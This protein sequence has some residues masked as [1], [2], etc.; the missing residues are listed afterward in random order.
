VG[1]VF[2]QYDLYSSSNIIRVIKSRR[3]RLAG[4]VVLMEE[5]RVA[6]SVLVGKPEGNRPLGRPRRRREDI[7]KMGLQEVESGHGLD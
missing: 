3:M 7:I 5:K 1:C 4:H 6:Y 2:I